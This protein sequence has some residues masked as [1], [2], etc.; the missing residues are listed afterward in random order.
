MGMIL[1]EMQISDQTHGAHI[2]VNK[3]RSEGMS[4]AV[5]VDDTSS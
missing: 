1:A 5:G 4:C 3:Q 2:P